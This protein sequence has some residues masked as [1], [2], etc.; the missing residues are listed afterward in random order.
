M[1]NS[2][3]GLREALLVLGLAAAALT[4]AVVPAYHGPGLSDEFV[5]MLGARRFA[6]T[7]SLD[8][9]LYDSISI[10][11]KGFPHQDVHS[12]GYVIVLGLF[13]RMVGSGYWSAVALNGLA[14][15]LSA[16]L[17]WDM[18]RHWGSSRTAVVSAACFMFLP[19]PQIFASWVMA[20]VVLGVC[21]LLALW[22]AARWGDRAAGGFVCGVVFGIAIL[23]RE[24]ALFGLPAVVALLSRSRRSVAGFAVGAALFLGLVYAPLSHARAPGGANF[25]APGGGGVFGFQAVQAASAG[26]PMEALR[27]AFAR[28]SINGSELWTASMDSDKA[29]LALYLLIPLWCF[30]GFSKLEPIRRRLLVGLSLGLLAM[31]T[32]LFFFYVVTQWSGYRYLMVLL[33]PFFTLLP[34]TGKERRISHARAGVAAFIL[35]CMLVTVR[36]FGVLDPF[37]RTS[38]PARLRVDE[39]AYVDHFI[40]KS[41]GRIVWQNGVGYALRH[42]PCEVITGIPQDEAT[43]RALQK[44]VWFD[45][46]VVSTWQTLF[47]GRERYELVNRADPDP[48]LK[49][50]RRLR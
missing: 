9:I 2:A 18:T 30:S 19:G 16:L 12:P 49:I 15:A 3:R 22:V 39:V 37:K 13:M 6:E 24:S 25:W 20:E 11:K 1:V 40:R 10:I 4:S 29:V 28:A 8:A 41:P 43:L 21:L 42:Y 33:P 38:D 23:V 32:V 31:V 44:A 27:L 17:V 45:Y 5:Y 36:M 50:Y 46:V 47:D 48:L 26:R 34:E 7:G 14:Y 35:V